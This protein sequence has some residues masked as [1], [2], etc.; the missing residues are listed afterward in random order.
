MAEKAILEVRR[1]NDQYFEVYDPQMGDSFGDWLLLAELRIEED[2]E[3]YVSEWGT[4]TGA[5][6]GEVEYLGKV[7]RAITKR[8]YTVED[9][10]YDEDYSWLVFS[11]G[12]TDGSVTD[13][14]AEAEVL[15]GYLG[16]RLMSIVR[17]DVSG[18]FAA[19]SHMR[20]MA[21]MFSEDGE[22]IR[23]NLVAN[24]FAAS[25]ELGMVRQEVVREQLL[26]VHRDLVS[27]SWRGHCGLDLPPFMDEGGE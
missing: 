24:A 3:C 12:G 9:R 19:V 22:L 20:D 10:P 25:C 26:K 16:E 7:M 5:L 1:L 23:G 17:E 27:G 14:R 21:G 6:I 13:E 8:A 18:A 15:T 2:T 11:F 4:D